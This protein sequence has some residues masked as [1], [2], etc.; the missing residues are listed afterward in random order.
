MEADV[1]VTTAEDIEGVC[2][3][4]APSASADA[5]TSLGDERD[6]VPSRL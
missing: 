1:R 5:P 2:R 6:G 3:E 4:V